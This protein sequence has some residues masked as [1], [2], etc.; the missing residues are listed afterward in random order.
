M[1]AGHM[2]LKAGATRIAQYAIVRWDW[3]NA[4]MRLKRSQPTI[5]T[6]L[7]TEMALL[8]FY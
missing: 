4:A 6:D 2:V 3:L 1:H 5:G 7:I 8:S